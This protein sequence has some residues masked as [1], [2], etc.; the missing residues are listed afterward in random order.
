MG[1]SLDLMEFI[2]EKIKVTYDREDFLIK[3]F[4][5]RDKEYKI[6]E[7]IST[8]Q[9]WKFSS[10]LS[11]K[12]TWLQ[13]HHRNYFIVKTDTAEIFQIYLDRKGNK[14]EWILLKKL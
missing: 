1:E 8:W 3:G 7:I 5:W 11:S 13:R 6:I 4:I 2:C 9:D 10:S 12:R 14:R